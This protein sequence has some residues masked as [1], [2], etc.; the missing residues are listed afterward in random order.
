M[1]PPRLSQVLLKPVPQEKFLTGFFCGKQHPR[2]LCGFLGATSINIIGEIWLS[3]EIGEGGLKFG[4]SQTFRFKIP[5]FCW[6]GLTV[7]E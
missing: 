6:Y 7:T 3:C 1:S 5:T 4:K 2:S